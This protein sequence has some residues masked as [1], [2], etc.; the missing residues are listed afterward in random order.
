M[1]VRIDVACEMF[2]TGWNAYALSRAT[3]SA[4]NISIRCENHQEL[5]HTGPVDQQKCL[6]Q[7]QDC[8][9]FLFLEF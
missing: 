9:P 2:E 1:N 7:N 6:P 4:E 8:R 3:N 5:L